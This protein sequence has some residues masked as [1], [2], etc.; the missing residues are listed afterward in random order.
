MAFTMR[1]SSNGQPVPC[2]V[3]D[4]C[5]KV[6]SLQEARVLVG[7]ATSLEDE[8]T[9]V[10]LDDFYPC[11]GRPY[12]VMVVCDDDCEFTLRGTLKDWHERSLNGHLG[13]VLDGHWSATD[14]LAYFV[15]QLTLTEQSE[16]H[17]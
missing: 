5:R 8:H 4:M 16:Q 1:L 10:V 7:Q 11:A 2:L 17:G 9:S 13:D 15:G 3:C 12:T 14:Y 6:A